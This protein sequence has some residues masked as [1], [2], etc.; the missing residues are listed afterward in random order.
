MSHKMTKQIATVSPWYPIQFKCPISQRYIFQLSSMCSCLTSTEIPICIDLH[1][2]RSRVISHYNIINIPI[3]LH[4][5]SHWKY[6][7]TSQSSPISLEI[8]PT[9]SISHESQSTYSW[10]HQLY[11]FKTK[12]VKKHI[13]WRYVQTT[14][15]KRIAKTM[16]SP[17]NVPSY[18]ITNQWR[19]LS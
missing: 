10:L 2:F 9:T 12:I 14:C 13:S 4:L 11:G 18:S 16:L 6:P 5:D 8:H 15:P 19:S 17:L 7:T 1:V 3:D